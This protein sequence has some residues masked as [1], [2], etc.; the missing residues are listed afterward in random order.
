MAKTPAERQA[1]C[2]ANRKE[3]LSKNGGRVLT[4]E[5][6]QG[7]DSDIKYLMEAGGF[8][9]ERE[10]LTILIKNCADSL[11]HDRMVIK[12]LLEL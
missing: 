7:T 11:T 6:Y 10:M 4:M 3:R 5:I 12:G 1:K 9:D 2:Y 8:E